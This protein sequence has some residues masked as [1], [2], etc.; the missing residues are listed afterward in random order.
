MGT[1]LHRHVERGSTGTPG[2][3]SERHDLSVTTAIGLGHALSDNR[4]RCDDDGA[5]R[6]IRVGHP[7]RLVRKTECAL[8]AHPAAAAAMR[9]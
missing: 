7:R 1:R 3:S 8:E 9:R 5:D 2:G 6:G 4:A